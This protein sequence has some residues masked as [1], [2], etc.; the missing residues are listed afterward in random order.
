[1]TPKTW[2]LTLTQTDEQRTVA[3]ND[4]PVVLHSLMYGEFTPQHRADERG[5]GLAA[6]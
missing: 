2:T 5:Q 3:H 1:M 4:M 6:A